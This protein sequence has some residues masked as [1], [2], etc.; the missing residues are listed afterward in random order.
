[1]GVTEG[2]KSLSRCEESKAEV[3]RPVLDMRGTILS[4]HKK[5]EGVVYPKNCR[6]GGEIR[7]FPFECIYLCCCCCCCCF[8]PRLQNEE[9]PRPG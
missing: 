8:W 7:K 2:V 3:E 5:E 9:I 4:C 6:S 1:M